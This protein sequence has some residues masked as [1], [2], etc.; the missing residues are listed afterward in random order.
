MSSVMC[1]LLLKLLRI[2]VYAALVV[3]CITVHT[4]VTR[5]SAYR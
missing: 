4:R 1:S 2:R 3:E 5:A